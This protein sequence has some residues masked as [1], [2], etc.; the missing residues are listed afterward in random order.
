M[1]RSV[2]L[3]ET[4]PECIYNQ[5]HSNQGEDLTLFCLEVDNSLSRCPPACFCR[6]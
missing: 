5:S 6:D 2:A 1:N 4:G 3:D